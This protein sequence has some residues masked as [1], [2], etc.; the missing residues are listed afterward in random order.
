MELHLTYCSRLT[1]RGLRTLCSFR[2]SLRSLSLFGCSSIFFRKSGAP[3]AAGE[4]QD[5]DEDEEE[6]ERLQQRTVDL[7]FSFQVD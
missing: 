6:E 1:S 3:L 5:E 2:H 7:D 4:D